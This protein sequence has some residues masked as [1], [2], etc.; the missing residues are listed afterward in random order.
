MPAPP[1]ADD[2]P[3]DTWTVVSPGRECGRLLRPTGH[4]QGH[5][6]PGAGQLVQLHW[7][8]L[9]N[10]PDQGNPPASRL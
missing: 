2:P 3:A 4:K 5:A 7:T 10:C 8:S 9:E 1:Q 6:S